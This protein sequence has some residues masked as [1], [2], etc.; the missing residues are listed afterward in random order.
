MKVPFIYSLKRALETLGIIIAD[1]VS[2]LV[3]FKVAV[4]MRTDILPHLH[5]GFPLEFPHGRIFD[6]WWIVL[7]WLFFFMYEGLYTKRFSYWDEVKAL[8]KTALYSV[9]SVLVI[10]SLG[11]LGDDVSRTVVVLMGML[12]VVVLPVIRM[13]VKRTLRSFGLLKR[14]A[15]ILGAGDTGCLVVKAL[16]REP[17][18]GYEVL[19]FIDDDP[20]LQGTVVE[21]LKVH[22]GL[23]E[24]DRYISRCRVQ[25][26]FIATPEEEWEKTKRLIN[27]LQQKAE[28]ILFVPGI[29]GV[30]MLGTNL[31]HFF[32]EQTFVLELKNNVSVP[33]N[34]LF[35]RCFDLVLCLLFMPILL[36]LIGVIS[37]VIKV[38]SRGPAMF[39]HVRV[40]Q[41]GRP[42]KCLKF[43]TMTEDAESK[44]DDMLENCSKVRD[45]WGKYRKLNDDPRVTRVGR[46]LRRTSL[47]ELPQILNV[48]TGSMSLV[49]PRPVTRDEIDRY[50]KDDAMLCYSMPPGITGLW[51]VSGRSSASYDYRIA[52]D[53]WYIR[54]WNPWMD[55]VILLRT[56]KVL[57][58]REGAW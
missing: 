22:G 37:F 10:A 4:F 38:D 43:R 56:V 27:S 23:M 24:A 8:W 13:A 6:N 49:G 36:V 16:K 45:E 40:G 21:G 52:L 58:S 47:D 25:D 7:L 53:S 26:V 34:I 5:D 32:H 12:G 15:I 9:V 20:D 35:K 18:Y 33:L 31:L 54:N 30:A 14:R 55:V 19:G 44:L 11:K 50:Y 48:L 41:N 1:M 57:I 2:I 51:Q 29:S 3:I 39:P 42:F 17:N 28:R 46:F